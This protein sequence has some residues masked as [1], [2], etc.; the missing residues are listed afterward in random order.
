MGTAAT[1][2][3]DQDCDVATIAG[4]QATIP[5]G[6]WPVIVSD[7]G[8]KVLVN[9]REIDTPPADWFRLQSTGRAT[10]K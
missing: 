4:G 3:F 8:A 5:R 7:F 1:Y 6:I 9:H 2:Q 10:K